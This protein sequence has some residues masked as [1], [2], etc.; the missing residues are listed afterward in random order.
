MKHLDREILRALRAK[1]SQSQ[2]SH[3]LGYK[4]NQVY[5]WE[6]G[7]RVIGWQDFVKICR[8]LKRPL[9]KALRDFFG[10][11]ED[12]EIH[13]L[14]TLILKS[15]KKGET[16]NSLAVTASKLSRWLSGQTDPPLEMVLRLFRM[17][18]PNSF[19]E[20]VD[21]V[22]G[23]GLVTSIQNQVAKSDRIHKAL[24]RYPFVGAVAAAL[25]T[26][27]YQRLKVHKPGVLAKQVGIT[28]DE[29]NAALEVLQATGEIEL[30]D[31][32][33]KI[34]PFAVNLSTNREQFIRCSQYWAERAATLPK[35]PSQKSAFGYRV[36]SMNYQHLAKIRQAQVDYYNALTEIIKSQEG[37]YDAVMV[38]N[39]QSFFPMEQPTT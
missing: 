6:S 18:Y 15:R 3:R 39:F 24:F 7:R 23:P 9:A 17:A 22:A 36:F 33:Y 4:Y 1:R 10:V 21:F 11:Q 38:I 37:P 28:I 26:K 12:L 13:Q 34:A 16:A 8:T 20:F 35:G 2:L 29:E 19:F 5:L 31:G 25:F 27:D 30:R 32:I 14:L